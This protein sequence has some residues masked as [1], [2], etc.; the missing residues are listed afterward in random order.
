MLRCALA[1]PKPHASIGAH[2]RSAHSSGS[3]VQ[4]ATGARLLTAEGPVQTEAHA[5]SASTL[6]RFVLSLQ[7]PMCR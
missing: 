1:E 6:F 5:S 2:A 7:C 3:S 4:Q